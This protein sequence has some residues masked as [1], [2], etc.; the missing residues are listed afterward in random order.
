MTSTK[1]KIEH[2]W[3]QKGNIMEPQNSNKSVHKLKEAA[4]YKNA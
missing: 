3:H 4:I 2:L 1:L